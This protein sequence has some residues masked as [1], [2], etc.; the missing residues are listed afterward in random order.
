MMA[1]PRSDAKDP[2][3]GLRLLGILEAEFDSLSRD[4]HE[5]LSSLGD[6]SKEVQALALDARARADSLGP[7]FAQV[8]GK[9][10]AMANAKQKLQVDM[11]TV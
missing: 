1:S 9:A 11:S 3:A 6:A 5:C 4:L 2:A 8:V 10:T 7:V